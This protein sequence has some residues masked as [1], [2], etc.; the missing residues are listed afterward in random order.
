MDTHDII[1][2]GSRDELFLAMEL[3]IPKFPFSPSCPYKEAKKAEDHDLNPDAKLIP[4]GILN[5]LTGLLTFFS[6]V[7]LKPVIS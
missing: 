6:V 5:V 1:F 2:L 7:H 4:Y 3:E